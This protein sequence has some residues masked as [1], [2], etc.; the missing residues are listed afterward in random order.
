MRP[1][2]LTAASIIHL[3]L[4]VQFGDGAEAAWSL[5][6]LCCGYVVRSTLSHG[7]VVLHD[8][9]VSSISWEA[10]ASP[11]ATVNESIPCSGGA[12]PCRTMAQHV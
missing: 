5:R 2:R 11:T 8:Q 7:L 9:L 10:Y 3:F 1:R 12:L 6:G 4:A